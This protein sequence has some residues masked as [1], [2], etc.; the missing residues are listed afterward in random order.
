MLVAGVV[1]GCEAGG[2]AAAG[3][4]DAAADGA[5]SP[6]STSVGDALESADAVASSLDVEPTPWI[7]PEEAPDTESTL[8][9]QDRAGAVHAALAA[10]LALD[11]DAIRDL[12]DLI[13]PPPGAGTGDLTGCPLQLT[14]D[15]GTQKAFYW[16]GECTASDGTMYSGMGYAS[17]FEDADFDGAVVTGYAYN[18]SGRIEAPDGT[19][20]EGAGDAN[21]LSGQNGE[22]YLFG[23][24]LNGT[25]KAGGPRAPSSVWLTGKRRPSVKYDGW[26]YGPTGGHNL[27]FT[28]GISGLED[29]PGGVTAVSLEGLTLRDIL[30]GSPCPS[31][32]GGVASVRGPDGAWTDIAFDGITDAVPEPDQAA[33]DGCGSSW[34]RGADVGETCV[35]PSTY[36]QWEGNRPW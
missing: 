11:P 28:G 14:Y 23:R 15:Y 9:A 34:F 18:M 10:V 4:P 6:D 33:C 35:S 8:S 27:A 12:H 5:T 26:V 31:E 25:F 24:G 19:W 13:F 36:L 17:W 29:F 21:S 22:I 30:A 16:Q 7:Y 2:D 20:L 32:P 3:G 1:L